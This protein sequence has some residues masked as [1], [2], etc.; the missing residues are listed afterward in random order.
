MSL[1]FDNHVLLEET[2]KAILTSWSHNEFNML[3]A[4]ATDLPRIIFVGEEGN[5]MPELE[6]RRGKN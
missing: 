4:V 3:L 1:F 2:E 5:L 6:I